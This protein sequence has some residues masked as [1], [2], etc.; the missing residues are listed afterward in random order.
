MTIN[1]SRDAAGSID[2]AVK[3]GQFASAAE[4]ITKLVREFDQRSQHQPAADPPPPVEAVKPIWE[5]FQEI[6]ATVPA[7][8][9]DALPTDLSEHH[10]HYLYGTPKP[11]DA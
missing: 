6:S 8:V 1:V 10:D 5:V 7:E 11:T 3:S 2:A 4:M 9:W